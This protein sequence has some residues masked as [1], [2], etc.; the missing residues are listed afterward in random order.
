MKGREGRKRYRMAE[1]RS[2]TRDL[3]KLL[4]RA[5]HLLEPVFE[6]GTQVTPITYYVPILLLFLLLLTWSDFVKLRL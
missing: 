2:R 5:G 4:L 6:P 3:H 1:V